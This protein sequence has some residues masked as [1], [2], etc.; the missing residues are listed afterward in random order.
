[1]YVETFFKSVVQKIKSVET[2]Q[3]IGFRGRWFAFLLTKPE[4]HFLNVQP[5]L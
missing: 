2:N 5:L 3:R 4:S 1:M